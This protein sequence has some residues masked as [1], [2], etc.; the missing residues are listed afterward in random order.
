MF[1]WNEK[2]LVLHGPRIYTGYVNVPVV[3]LPLPH[4]SAELVQNQPCSDSPIYKAQWYPGR[5]SVFLNILLPA[6]VHTY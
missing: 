2:W 5:T 6:I 3:E 4:Y 1:F